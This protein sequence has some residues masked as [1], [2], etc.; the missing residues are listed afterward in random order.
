MSRVLNASVASGVFVLV[1]GAFAYVSLG[2]IDIGVVREMGPGYMPRL[3]AWL[4]LGAGAAMTL[5]GLIKGGEPLP[6]FQARAL[7]LI[8]LA[9]VVFGATVDR[10]GMVVAVVVSTVIASLASPITRHRETPVLCV[11]L[12]LGACLVFI[13]GLGLPISI[14]PR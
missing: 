8:S 13:K 1:I 9:T 12:A 3:L 11:L 14:W 4:I 5:L 7:L 2:G 6:A 10:F